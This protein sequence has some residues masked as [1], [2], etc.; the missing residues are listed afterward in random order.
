[1]EAKCEDTIKL[2]RLK[3]EHEARE[4]ER[5]N[6]ADTDGEGSEED[7][8]E[9]LLQPQSNQG[10]SA[11]GAKPISCDVSK[12][13]VGSSGP[14]HLDAASHTAAAAEQCDGAANGALDSE[15]KEDNFAAEAVDAGAGDCSS[16]ADWHVQTGGR[17]L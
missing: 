13:A 17:H 12:N 11:F 2:M 3:M 9:L 10:F 7:A 6:K 14:K 4:K 1:M 15:M 8:N 5:D 16:D